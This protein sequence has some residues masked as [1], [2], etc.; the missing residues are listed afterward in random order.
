MRNDPYLRPVSYSDIFTYAYYTWQWFELI[1]R[2]GLL[3][4]DPL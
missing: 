3:R 2:V 1:G 4:I